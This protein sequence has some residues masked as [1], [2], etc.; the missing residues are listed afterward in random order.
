MECASPD[1]KMNSLAFLTTISWLLLLE[2]FRLLPQFMFILTLLR[3]SLLD[4]G[5]FAVILMII[6]IGFM[7]GYLRTVN[8]C[9]YWE[10]GLRC[11]G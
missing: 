9:W 6:N 10:G 4:M 8:E 3:A 2:H 11:V 5:Y 7:F 1:Q